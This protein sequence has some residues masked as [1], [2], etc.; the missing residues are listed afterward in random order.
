MTYRSLDGGKTWQE[1]FYIRDCAS[2]G[3]IA[4]LPSGKL[5]LVIRYQRELR[6]SDPLWLEEKT[7]SKGYKH[8]FLADSEDEGKNWQNWRQ[9]TTVHGQ[10]HGYAT[11]QS[12]GVVVVTHETRYGPGGPG[13]RAM[14]SYD[15]GQTW[16]DE[17]YYLDYSAPPNTGA[18]SSSVVLEDD[19]ILTLVPSGIP[20][21]AA[22]TPCDV[23]AIR[24]KPE[25]N[26]S[27]SEIGPD[28]YANQK[29][30]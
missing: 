7:G 15:E 11:A 8:I 12:D 28:S 3:G 2:E 21:T 19:T 24:W 26:E 17:V 25:K 16:E 13:S 29:F 1:R 9:L 23:T 30:N 10:A 4:E 14:I 22:W 6:P 27:R 5:L 20:R 18:Y